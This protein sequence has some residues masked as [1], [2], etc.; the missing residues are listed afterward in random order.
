MGKVQNYLTE[1][2]CKGWESTWIYLFQ[3]ELTW[4]K[5]TVIHYRT[6]GRGPYPFVGLGKVVWGKAES[7]LVVDPRSGT[8]AQSAKQ[9]LISTVDM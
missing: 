9:Q 1:P 8:C 2:L 3:G 4:H 7:Q 5:R 6:G